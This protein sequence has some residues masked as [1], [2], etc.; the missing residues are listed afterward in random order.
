MSFLPALKIMS[1]SLVLTGSVGA[2]TAKI[3]SHGGAFGT[4]LSNSTGFNYH[5]ADNVMIYG[6]NAV[7]IGD[8]LADP[9]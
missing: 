6:S 1:V 9:R 8:I 5:E 3:V 2:D 4:L 7:P